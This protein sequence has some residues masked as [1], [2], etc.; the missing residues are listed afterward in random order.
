MCSNSSCGIVEHDVGIHLD[1]AAI[2]VEREA[3]VAG[4]F[5]E[6]FGGLVVE[7]EIED[8]VHHAGH[9]GAAARAD[10]DQQRIGRVAEFLA[11]AA[12]ER[13]EGVCRPGSSRSAGYC[14]LSW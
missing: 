5:G 2:A 8:G 12:F 3:A 7:A 1:E 10:G 4:E 11:G 14:F 9:G 13:G 6:A